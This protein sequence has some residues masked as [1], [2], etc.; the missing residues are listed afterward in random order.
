MT[1]ALERDSRALLEKCDSGS[2]TPCT[3]EILLAEGLGRTHWD[4]TAFRA[5]LREIPESVRAGRLVDVLDPA[6]PSSG[7]V[8]VDRTSVALT[9]DRVR[10]L[11]DVLADGGQLP[12]P[13]LAIED[14]HAH[15][16][17]VLDFIDT[18]LTAGD[19][20]VVEDSL[21]KRAT[22]REFL[23]SS[24]HRYQLDTRYLDLFG[25]NTSSAIDSILRRT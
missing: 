3:E 9:D 11:D 20:L 8:S 5:A 25:E 4:G 22:L 1:D 14:A 19:Y 23:R 7:G 10:N 24:P 13:W 2:W 18:Q 6:R 21:A 16:R 17:G 12:R 15:V